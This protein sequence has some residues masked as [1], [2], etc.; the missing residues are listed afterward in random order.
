LLPITMSGDPETGEDRVQPL[1]DATA[2]VQAGDPQLR[3]EEVGGPSI[4]KALDDTLGE[5]FQR[6]E[7]LSLPVTR[8]S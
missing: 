7:L 4:S 5:D 1:L 3:V 8:R 2:S 6:A